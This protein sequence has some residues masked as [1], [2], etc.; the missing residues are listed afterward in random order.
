[1]AKLLSYYC[2]PKYL[3]KALQLERILLFL[4]YYTE[5]VTRIALG[6]WVH[7]HSLTEATANTILPVYKINN[8]VAIVI[9]VAIVVFVRTFAL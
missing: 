8:V 9:K 6:I 4:H 7:A 5:Y 1:M 2:I 3:T